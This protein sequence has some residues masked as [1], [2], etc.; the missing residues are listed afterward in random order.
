MWAIRSDVAAA[1]VA[2]EAQT[3]LN[4]LEEPQPVP[5]WKSFT[6]GWPATRGHAIPST[7]GSWTS[8]I[9]VQQTRSL[10]GLEAEALTVLVLDI[11]KSAARAPR[12]IGATLC[13][14]PHS[15]LHWRQQQRVLG[16]REM[17]FAMQ[18]ASRYFGPRVMVPVRE[19]V[20]GVDG[21]G[22]ERLR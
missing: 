7:R 2:G 4:A 13:A 21:H 16:T 18:M 9:V 14:W 12:C 5:L 20:A 17:F 19:A 1:P 15:R 3:V 10:Q 8:W 22:R 11:S 6:G